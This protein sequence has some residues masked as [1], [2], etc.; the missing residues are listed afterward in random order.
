MENSQNDIYWVHRA[1]CNS[2]DDPDIFFP[3]RD[4]AKYKP[5]ADKAKAICFGKDGKPPCPVRKNCLKE[6]IVSDELHGIWGG[7]S[8][9]E[10]NAAIRKYTSAGLTLDEWLDKER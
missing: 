5:I 10:R 9:R 1:K 2:V 8:H 6:A 3:P 4:K 7:L